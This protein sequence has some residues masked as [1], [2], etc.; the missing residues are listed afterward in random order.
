MKK[1]CIKF[2][3][4][5][6]F[7]SSA[8]F[9]EY[10]YRF[11]GFG[12]GGHTSLAFTDYGPTFEFGGHGFIGLSFGRAGKLQIIPSVCF[13]VKSD[14]KNW[15]DINNRYIEEE[16]SY[17]QIALNLT[18]I[19]YTIPIPKDIFIQ[20]YVGIGLLCFVINVKTTDRTETDLSSGDV[21]IHPEQ[22]DRGSN[23]CINLFAGTDFPVSERIVPFVEFRFTATP[24]QV[25]RI[26]GGISFCF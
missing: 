24:W 2:L 26:V 10:E 17:S 7:L 14:K 3:S 12:F 6:L 1:E 25:F 15:D 22:K 11:N 23:F 19:K 8:A 21:T 16:Y 20:P 13:W 18:D 5:I 4:L 9:C